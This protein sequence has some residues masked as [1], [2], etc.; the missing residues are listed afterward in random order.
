MMAACRTI[1][2]LRLSEGGQTTAEW[3]LLLAVFGIPMIFVFA[4]GLR[5]LSTHYDMVT[6]LE[7]LPLP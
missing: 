3:A 6:L 4:M 5:V 7:T 2:R 1:R